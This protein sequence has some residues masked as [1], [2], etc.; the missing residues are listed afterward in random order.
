M[1]KLRRVPWCLFLIVFLTIGTVIMIY[2]F[3]W[4]VSASFKEVAEM[5]QIP[6]TIIPRNP[7]IKNYQVVFQQMGLLAGMYKNSIIVSASITVLQTLI[8]SLAAFVF[9]KMRF[10]GKNVIFITFMAAMMV[11]TQLTVIPNYF[12]I[13][14]LG[15]MDNL[16]SLILI[17]AFSAFAIFLIRQFFM[18]LPSEL[19]DAAKI[20]GCG[21]FRSYLLIHLPLAKSVLAVNA[22]LCFNGAWGDF[23]NPL[24]FLKSIQSMTLPLG[25]SMLQGMYS[26]QSPAVNVATMVV[27]LVPVLIVFLIGRKRLIAGVATT[28]MKM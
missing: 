14:T 25:L 1:K 19:D 27:A 21:Y 11:P 16:G 13:K 6:P 26:Q 8:G 24:I 18:S 3:I 23:F 7:T 28:G 10:P 17:G 9:A 22:I 15:L 5:Y 2:P 20:D 4:M 12:I